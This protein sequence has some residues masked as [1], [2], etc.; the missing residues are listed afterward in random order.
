[1]LLFRTLLFLLV[2]VENGSFLWW[3]IH[4]PLVFDARKVCRRA[5]KIKGHQIDVC[6]DMDMATAL[7]NGA[8]MGI[9]ECHHQ[10][11]YERW[12][13]T[14]SR[15]SLDKML[16]K[17]TQES[18]FVQALSS[19]GAVHKVSQM[20]SAGAL[21]SC[22]CQVQRA[23]P[24]NTSEDNQQSFKYTGCS[25]NVD[26]ATLKARELF[27]VDLNGRAYGGIR[28]AVLNHNNEVG[29]KVVAETMRRVC[30]C[31]GLSG[32]CNM[33]TCIFRV[34]PFREI[35]LELREKYK[36]ARSVTPGND[37]PY[38][39][40]SET[41]LEQQ[42]QTSAD[43]SGHRRRSIPEH[44]LVYTDKSPNFCARDRTSGIISPRGRLCDPSASP[45]MGGCD[46]LC[47][48]RGHELAATVVRE[49]NCRCKFQWCCE[50]N[51][52]ICRNET[53]VF[54]CR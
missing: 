49:T 43:H 46:Y 12:N 6:R 13:C 30:K 42:P 23:P 51:C 18:A 31:H 35:G 39:L 33:K 24:G 41:P 22:I 34:R 2:A 40:W 4:K 27:D 29:R 28:A 7:L 32:S 21:R 26:F 8:H 45:D 37:D 52:E 19:A 38:S 1:M 53:E 3:S 54:R 20:C 14:T 16:L 25:D 44:D 47:C 17:D 11:R 15:R 50:V 9:F 5:R 10:L 48:G 36:Q